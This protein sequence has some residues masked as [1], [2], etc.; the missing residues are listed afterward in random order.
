VIFADRAGPGR[1]IGV[2]LAVWDAAAAV[3]HRNPREMLVSMPVG[4]PPFQDLHL[5]SLLDLVSPMG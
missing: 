3:V 4:F 2:G 5:D 1:G